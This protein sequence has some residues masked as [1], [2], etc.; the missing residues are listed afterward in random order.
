MWHVFVCV[1]VFQSLCVGVCVCVCVLGHQYGEYVGVG[2]MNDSV[3]LNECL[4]WVKTLCFSGPGR[5]NQI[6]S[7]REYLS[8]SVR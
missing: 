3:D 7:P 4:S 1:R 6:L 5:G 8:V 2:C